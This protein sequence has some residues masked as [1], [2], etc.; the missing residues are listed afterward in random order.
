MATTVSLRWRVIDIVTAAVLGVACG[1]IF[2]AW[3]QVGYAGYEALKAIA[4]GLGGLVTGVW[5]LGGT[6]GGYII[7]KPGSA[8]FV[9]LVAA[10][11]SMG[12]GSQW[13]VETLYSGLAQ[14]IG[15]EIVFALFAYRRFN[16]WVAAAAGALSFVCEWVLE[17]FLSGHLAK[18]PLYNAIY[19]VSGVASG[20]VLAGV[21]AWAL[22]NALAKTGALDRF[23]SGRGARELVDSRSMNEASSASPRPVSSP[24]G[25]APLGEGAGARVRAREWGWRHAGR[26]N[27][28]LSGVDL[29]IAPGERVLVL[30][31]SGS[32]KSTLM[33]GLAGLLGG[34]EEGEATGTLTV[35]GVAPAQARGRVGLLMQDPEAQVV[36]AR[37]GDD[38][39]FG[40]ENLGVPREEIW[41]RVEE[42]LS[43]VGL[44]APLDHSTTEL[45]GGQKQRLALAS[46]LAMG[47]GLL[48]LDEPT[49]N[50][51]PGGIAEVRDV[52]AS[53]VERTGATLVVVEHR[54][55]VWASLVDRVIVVAD[56][57]IAADGP[58]RQV[59]EEQ[60]EALRERGIWLPGDDVAAE[61]GPAPEIAPASSADTPIARV[62]DLMIG[63]DQDAPVRSG[64][65]LTLERGV[66]TCIVGANGAG[67]STFALT[68]AGLLPPLEGTVEVETADGTA[69]DP[70]GWP[71]K[72]LL[73]RMSMVFQ[74]PEYQFLASTVAEELAIGPRAVGMTEEEIAPLVEEHLEA[75]G[76]TKLA[77]ANPMTLSGG[78]KRRLS[79]ATALI[80]APELLI[81]DEPT[82]G[83]DRGTWLGL[84]RLLR[85]ALERGVT[86]VSITHDPAFV[87]AM[88]QRV[89]DLGLVGIRGGGESRDSAESAPTSARAPR[90]GLLART[91]PV[92]RVLA[93]LVATTPLLISI[94]PVSAGVALALELAL[95]PLSGVSARSFALKATP[96]AVAAPLGALSM[97]LYA[98]PGGRVF[99][100]FGPAAISEHSIWLA[101]GIGLR[102]CALVI[103]AIALLDRIDPT[104]MG[105][106]L[107]QILH[108]P[109]R[110][111]LASLAGARM[112]S[113]MAADW[114][115][116]ERARRARGVGDA[117]RIRS[118]LRGSFSLLVFALRRSGKLATTMEARG[119]G[120]KGQ[121]TWARPSRLRAADAV[122]IAVAVA[123]PAI[124]LAVSV[125]AGTFALVGR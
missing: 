11:V 101:L 25:R 35:D 4:P 104:D 66:S 67:K 3:N 97:L 24:D 47:P 48:L 109:A 41:P 50:L 13:A 107:A 85:S 40:M 26:K 70:H 61:V 79:V 81:L 72:R 1:L 57:R 106:G 95:I 53:V 108:L 22:T 125:W 69:G 34:A 38:V 71:S 111:V 110:P 74:E 52:V 65:N 118:F 96:L 51:D 55:D 32:G 76:L 63:Y 89:V 99:W 30:G 8:L 73:G 16:V 14:G 117:S 91:N 6:L 17:L 82:F 23:A 83:Q 44:D 112:T 33:G 27:A 102:M 18:G 113:L 90:R 94:D 45:S 60:G 31:P 37:V 54:V 121:R 123:I 36:L 75:L 12:L 10:T 5:L 9:E 21:L 122:L 86:L 103:P 87:A 43:A 46:I 56:G 42:S 93:L 62:T 19:L 116:L 2:V 105:D 68:L 58:L 114:K 92:A 20:I 7:R 49:A 15:A 88:G 59:L 39:A 29:D 115:A 80:S 100:E 84:V 28:A 119:F 120:A 78:E 77:R 124:A 98:S 64:I